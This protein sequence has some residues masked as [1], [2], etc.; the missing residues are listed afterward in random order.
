MALPRPMPPATNTGTSVITG[1]ISCASTVR[2][3]GPIWPPASEPSMMIASTPDRTSFLASAAV[4]AKHISLAPKPLIL[5]I[6]APDGSP[7]ASTTWLTPCRPQIS[8]SSSSCGCR[9]IRFTP[10]GLLV[11]ARVAMISASRMAGGIDPQAITPKP[12][13]LEMAETR[14]RSETQVIAPAMMAWRVPRNSRPLA[15]AASRWGVSLT[16]R[17]PHLR[18]YRR[19]SAHPGHRPCAARARPVR[20]N[21]SGSAHSP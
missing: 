19:Q 11:S 12:P 15:D 21:P 18:P 1:R 8:I 14:W 5:A 4:G 2:L 13:A 20:H 16:H 7:P 3:T 9:V 17:S 6:A 10:N